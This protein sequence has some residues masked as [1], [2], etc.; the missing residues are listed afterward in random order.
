MTMRKK[1]YILGLTV[2]LAV[3]S[4]TLILNTFQ[5]R[6]ERGYAHTPEARCISEGSALVVGMDPIDSARYAPI[7]ALGRVDN[8][9]NSVRVVELIKGQSPR[10]GDQIE[11]CPMSALKKV[12]AGGT[13][14]IFLAGFDKEE[15]QWVL[16]QGSDS[17]LLENKNRTFSVDR[18]SEKRVYRLVDIREAAKNQ[19]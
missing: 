19:K 7:V 6:D 8:S 17:M 1:Q 4:A 14:M 13:V 15:K 3:V 5:S 18:S 12:A 2:L 9:G 16:D 10:L 11:L